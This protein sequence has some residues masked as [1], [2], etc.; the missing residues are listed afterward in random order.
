[1]T[2]TVMQILARAKELGQNIG[3]KEIAE[4]IKPGDEV[5][6]VLER[7][8]KVGQVLKDDVGYWI[9]PPG[10]DKP[11]ADF[12]VLYIPVLNLTHI[13]GIPIDEGPH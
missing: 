4:R 9:V 2:P 13:N 10:G 7:K 6:T 12:S 1:M 3:E 8:V 11:E 5:T